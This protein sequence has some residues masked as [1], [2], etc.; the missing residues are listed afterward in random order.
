MKTFS[1]LLAVFFLT[2]LPAALACVGCR[3]PGTAGPDEPQ[4]ITAGIAL[5]WGVVGMLG[6]VF[7]IV[8]AQ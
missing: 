6:V 5:S 3:A 4:T 2:R 1:A 7:L 8:T